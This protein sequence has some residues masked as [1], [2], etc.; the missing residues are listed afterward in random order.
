MKFGVALQQLL[1]GFLDAKGST[2][3]YTGPVDG[4][5]IFKSMS[6]EDLWP[7]SGVIEL[8]RYLKGNRSLHIPEGWRELLPTEL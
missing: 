8:I 7:E 1:P 2:P 3:E 4:K 5:A 6:M